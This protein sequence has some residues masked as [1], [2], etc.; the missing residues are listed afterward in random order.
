MKENLLST[1]DANEKIE[2]LRKNWMSHDARYQMAIVREF[3]WEKGN[4]LNKVIIHD[5]GK[6]MM[7]RLM[8]AL[9][10]S[11]VKSIDELKALCLCAICFYYP[12]PIFSYHIEEISETDL[13]GVVDKCST[14]DNIKKIGVVN[15]Y[16]CGCFA[17]RS[18]WYKALGMEVEEIL[19]TCLKNGD[20]K[21]KILLKV[22]N[23]SK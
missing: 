2:I 1:I 9:D 11:K 15:Q 20:K 10:I 19:L 3:G 17:M 13:L 7:Y 14:Y 16:E 5:M 12:E 6:V 21:C 18:G 22:K 8:N 23:W 4:K